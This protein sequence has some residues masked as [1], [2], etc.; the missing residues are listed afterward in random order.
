MKDQKHFTD[1]VQAAHWVD[2]MARGDRACLENLFRVFAPALLPVGIAI[3]RSRSDAEEILHEVF[4]EAWRKA[5]SFDASRGSVHA[6]LVVR[7]RSRCLDRLKSNPASR[8]VPWDEQSLAAWGNHPLGLEG[9]SDD[10][11]ERA[12]DFTKMKAALL[13]VPEEQRQVILLGYFG[14]LSASEMAEQ[15]QVPLG[16]I[17]SRVRMALQRLKDL[18]QESE[19]AL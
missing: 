3:L 10:N 19:S 9:A 13:Q 18:L 7:M 16:T 11:P 12:S 2:G 6:W 17:K 4:L 14:G 8:H 1:P 5:R 15:L